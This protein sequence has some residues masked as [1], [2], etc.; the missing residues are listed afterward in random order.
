MEFKKLKSIPTD[1]TVHVGEGKEMKTFECYRVVLGMHSIYFENMF[2]SSMV[3]A[4]SH[5]LNLPQFQPEQFELFYTF[6]LPSDGDSPELT[7]ENVW[8]LAPLFHYFQTPGWLK[9]CDEV[10]AAKFPSKM[11]LYTELGFWISSEEKQLSMMKHFFPH[12]NNCATWDLS[13][14]LEKGT[15]VLLEYLRENVDAID[16]QVLTNMMDLSLDRRDVWNFIVKITDASALGIDTEYE[17]AAT[18]VKNEV[19]PCTF[20]CAL[21]LQLARDEIKKLEARRRD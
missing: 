14:A 10:M 18:L 2:A 12:L 3:E 16:M 21:Q 1:V 15:T 5:V 13:I 19:M 9:K 6:C 8:L 17:N 11:G 7:V 4:S 20:F